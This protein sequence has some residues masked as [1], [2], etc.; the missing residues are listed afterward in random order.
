MGWLGWGGFQRNLQGRIFV[1]R[2]EKGIAAGVQQSLADGLILP[3]W[4]QTSSDFLPKH[5]H[6]R[7]LGSWALPGGT[8]PV[9]FEQGAD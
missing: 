6:A 1:P 3:F 9:P 2:P 4:V 8:P 7:T 5:A